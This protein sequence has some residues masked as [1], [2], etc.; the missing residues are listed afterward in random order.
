MWCCRCLNPGRETEGARVLARIHRYTLNRLR[1]EISPV[2]PADFMRFLF[3]WQHVDPSSALT[4]PDGLRAVIAQLDGVELPA[5]AWERDVLKAR[6]DRYD[7]AL[8]DMLCLTGE[9]AWA[10]LSTGPTQVVGATPIA[11]SCASTPTRGW[12]CDRAIP[13]RQSRTPFSNT[14]ART[15]P[16]R[17]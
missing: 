10:R 16:L 12:R 9:V 8:L 13:T 5:R 1:A 4:G 17:A 14:C 2:T 7:P 15:A 6:V 3:A 11:L